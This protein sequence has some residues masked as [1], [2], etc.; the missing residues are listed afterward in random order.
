ML[1]LLTME[2]YC[3]HTAHLDWGN[4]IQR[5]RTSQCHFGVNDG[6]CLIVQLF[7]SYSWITNFPVYGR[8]HTSAYVMNGICAICTNRQVAPQLSLPSCWSRWNLRGGGGWNSSRHRTQAKFQ[9]HRTNA[10]VCRTCLQWWR[11][12]RCPYFVSGYLCPWESV[13]LMKGDSSFRFLLIAVGKIWHGTILGILWFPM[14][15]CSGMSF[16]SPQQTYSGTVLLC[17]LSGY[18]IRPIL[19]G[20]SCQLQPSLLPDPRLF[21]VHC[22]KLSGM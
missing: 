12:R 2:I 5:H 8:R 7:S 9:F 22:S 10:A 15:L 4:S 17:W 21:L 19:K 11:E 6:V 16:C 18:E 1:D 13:S 3:R 20:V 14:Y